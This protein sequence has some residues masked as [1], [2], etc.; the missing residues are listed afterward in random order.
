[1]SQRTSSSLFAEV[2]GEQGRPTA[3]EAV[4]QPFLSVVGH[5]GLDIDDSFR[6][7]HLLVREFLFR[8]AD[9]LGNAGL[10]WLSRTAHPFWQSCFQQTVPDASCMD[11]EARFAAEQEDWAAVE[12]VVWTRLSSRDALGVYYTP[13][14]LVQFL[15]DDA[16]TTWQ[17]A[18]IDIDETLFVDPASGGGRF[19]LGLIRR[20]ART[21]DL[22]ELLPRVVAMDVRPSALCAI[23]LAV[24]LEL[25][26]QGCD[27]DACP[28]LP[29]AL[30]DT[31][32]GSSPHWATVQMPPTLRWIGV[33]GNPPFSSLSQNDS[34]WIRDLLAGRGEDAMDVSYSAVGGRKSG[35]RKH[36][37]HDDYVKFL[38]WAHWRL[39]SVGAGTIHFV[40]GRGIVDNTSFQRLREVLVNDFDRVT[41]VNLQGSKK[42]GNSP[43]DEAVFEIE[44]GV[45]L[46]G[47]TKYLGAGESSRRNAIFSCD[48]VGTREQKLRTLQRAATG[49]HGI[50]WEERMVRAPHFLFSRTDAG[51]WQRFE[52][53]IPLVDF[54]RHS[55]SAIV[56][57]RDS[58]VIAP[59]RE[60]LMHRLEQLADRRV[61]TDFLRKEFFPRARSRKYP[62]GD[63]RGWS[64]E[65]ARCRLRETSSW[66]DQIVSVD[67][68]PWDRRVMLYLPW[69]IDWLRPAISDLLLNGDNPCLVSRKQMVPDRPAN[70]FWLT[71]LPT[72][73]GIIRSDNRGNETLFPLYSQD[74]R[75]CRTSNLEQPAVAQFAGPAGLAEELEPLAVF[76]CLFATFFSREYQ[77]E[78]QECLWHAMPRVFPLR[79]V[80]SFDALSSLGRR[81]RHCLTSF[82]DSPIAEM[83]T[84]E[85]SSAGSSGS[86]E[87]LRYGEE[88]IIGPGGWRVS[89]ETDVWEF[90][91]GSHQVVRKWFRDH[92]HLAAK[93]RIAQFRQLLA[94]IQ[95]AVQLRN[96]LSQFYRDGGGFSQ[97]HRC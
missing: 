80:E 2:A 16:V 78:F 70:F 67:Y 77:A 14:P 91:V 20:F 6:A 43:N 52:R 13:E 4:R 81:L 1:M 31:L 56:T 60:T 58:L 54:F 47:L 36:W 44:S 84:L 57:A 75:G 97:V 66:R 86:S 50:M 94:R 19:I 9:L 3:D 69:M 76:D 63:T 65:E 35:R 22:P 34:V 7:C 61:A 37:L 79:A 27:F 96:E 11:R 30:G 10:R 48:L 17:R 12:E 39:D 90:Q 74:E 93:E 38:R 46:L 83:E 68:R 23:Q 41:V 25:T 5:L 24:A 62:R 71:Q 85:I 29:L 92:G 49:E 42:R 82:S 55:G 33:L 8:H 89:A 73:D 32:A 51:Q 53:G 72:L 40:L 18:A 28:N 87:R 21:V 15:V 45:T 59:D 64:L 95:Q 26:R 88:E